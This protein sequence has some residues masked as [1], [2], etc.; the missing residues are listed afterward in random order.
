MGRLQGPARTPRGVAQIFLPGALPGRAAGGR[1]LRA[2]ALGDGRL[3]LRH[4]ERPGQQQQ[5]APRRRAR[6]AHGGGLRLARR[7]R[8][9][10]A[11]GARRPGG[12]DAGQPVH[13]AAARRLS[14]LARAADQARR[15]DVRAAIAGARRHAHLPRRR[16]AAR[17]AAPRSLGLADRE[18]GARRG[19][20]GRRAALQRTT[21]SM[22]TLTPAASFATGGLL[23]SRSPG[24]GFALPD[25]A[26]RAVTTTRGCAETVRP[27]A[28]AIASLRLKAS[29]SS[30]ALARSTASGI[31]GPSA[32]RAK[33]KT[34]SSGL[35][36]FLNCGAR[37]TVPRT[38]GCA[39]MPASFFASST[40]SLMLRASSE[41]AGTSGSMRPHSA[42]A[43][44]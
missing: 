33:T 22:S 12:G 39:P 30:P 23:P 1:V 8:D 32:A 3:P 15:A 4:A 37:R 19:R 44:A 18:L 11:E 26:M 20:G 21:L 28:I 34:V 6:E 7:L 40:F 43:P 29:G 27:C 36:S 31:G 35:T 14:G 24:A 25:L 13:H 41:S 17:R 9:A 16:A 2:H 42:A 38:P 10:R 5:R